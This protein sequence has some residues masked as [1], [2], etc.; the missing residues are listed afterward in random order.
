M[1]HKCS[2]CFYVVDSTF[3][4]PQLCAKNLSHSKDVEL[5]G[6]YT[7]EDAVGNEELCGCSLRWYAS[8]DTPELYVTKDKSKPYVIDTG[9]NVG[10]EI[11]I[12]NGIVQISNVFVG[13]NVVFS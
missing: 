5:K 10:T 6:L 8:K 1:A 13:R 12:L 4:C 9:W 2:S 3:H 7:T 11:T